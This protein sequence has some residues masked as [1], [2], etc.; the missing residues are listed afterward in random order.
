MVTRFNLLIATA[1]LCLCV[2]PGPLGAAD[3]EDV[4]TKV[5]AAIDSL[6]RADLGR[7]SSDEKKAL[8]KRLDDAWEFILDHPKE[9]RPTSQM[10][11]RH[12]VTCLPAVLRMLELKELTASI[13]EHALGVDVNLGLLFTIGQYGDA[14]LD[15]VR[16]GL[17]SQDCVTR[18]NAAFII[19]LLLPASQPPT[20]QDIAMNDPCETTR[21]KAWFSVGMFAEP[22][23]AGMAAK[24]LAAVP[25][26]SA[27][28]RLAIARALTSS[29]SRAVEAPLKSLVDDPDAK[30]AAAA[31]KSWDD[32]KE[33]ART[34][35]ELRTQVGSAS[36]PDRSK[37]HGALQQAKSKGHFEF[38]G[39]RDAMLAA[40]DP[41]DQS[42][43]NEARAAV[44][45]RLSDECLDEYYDPTF[46]A[47]VLR[48]IGVAP[49]A[50]VT[51]LRTPR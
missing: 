3:E 33:D 26:P 30:V 21:G 22:S 45:D 41:A 32:L 43:V 37:L 34:P 46:L 49:P 2:G 38:N 39:D 35:A 14:A 48:L 51:E 42:L 40:L 47:R 24:R 20:L 23:L 19:G 31:R 44:L 13:P 4:Q 6:H 8:G 29:F 12:C 50:P 18:G 10:A 15:G 27:E 36:R 16:V 25:P 1:L 28:E 17:Q 7:M 9:A 5:A 11:A